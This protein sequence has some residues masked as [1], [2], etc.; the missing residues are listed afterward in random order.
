MP[1][2]S[3][4]IKKLELLRLFKFNSSALRELRGADRIK[5]IDNVI[6]KNKNGIWRIKYWNLRWRWVKKNKAKEQTS[7]YMKNKIN[8]LRSLI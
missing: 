3:T 4:N 6:N 2:S 8:D 7:N 1:S 5:Y